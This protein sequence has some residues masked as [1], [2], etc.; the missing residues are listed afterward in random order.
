[1]AFD[2][3]FEWRNE[4]VAYAAARGIKLIQISI[5]NNAKPPNAT[6]RKHVADKCRDD[7]KLEG[8]GGTYMVVPGALMRGVVTAVTWVMGSSS[9]VKNFGNVVEAYEAA[10][11]Y[12]AAAGIEAPNFE[13]REYTLPTDTNKA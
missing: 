7:D 13:A 10:K 2:P 1:M 6:V 9:I 5:T 8:L 12:F 11:R 3:Y 4:W